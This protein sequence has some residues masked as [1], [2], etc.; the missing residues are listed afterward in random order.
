MWNKASLRARVAALAALVCIAVCGLLVGALVHS[1]GDT[2]RPGAG[3]QGEVTAGGMAADL[4]RLAAAAAQQERRAFARQSLIWLAAAAAIGAGAAWFLARQAIRPVSELSRRIESIDVNNLAEPVP[5]PG[6]RDE[7][8][9]LARSFN[10]LLGKLHDAFEAQKRFVQNAAHELKTPVTAILANIEVLELD[11]EPSI[12]D[13]REA[14]RAIKEN[15][16]R[17]SALVEDLLMFN[18]QCREF[19]AR[20]SF[21]QLVEEIRAELA[22]ESDKRGIVFAVSGDT[23]LVGNRALLKRAFRN[24]IHNSI[25]YNRDGGR[26]DISCRDG[27]IVVA[28]TGIGIPAP[29]VDKVFEPFYCVDAS[30]SRQLGGSGL[31]LALAKQ[32]FDQHKYKVEVRSAEAQ[33]TLFI[34]SLPT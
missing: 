6:S 32:I 4:Y 26:I 20:F 12:E 9:R 11:E 30:R 7:V 10:N 27:Q 3:E 1:A 31:G 33:G 18:V 19:C 25:R 28:D 13:C 16:W 29:H 15:A 24:I 8:A 5:V 2:F 17:M 14:I 22:T 23:E 34:I 21:R